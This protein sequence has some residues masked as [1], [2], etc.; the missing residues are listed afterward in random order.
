MVGGKAR[1]HALS[2]LATSHIGDMTSGIYHRPL[3][4][5]TKYTLLY[6][7]DITYYNS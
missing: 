5:T 7:D 6:R 2:A 4:T 1:W 3:T